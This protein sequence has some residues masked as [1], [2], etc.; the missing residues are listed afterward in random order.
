MNEDFKKKR[1]SYKKK[2]FDQFD[3]NLYVVIENTY[4][5]LNKHTIIIHIYMYINRKKKEEQKKA[6]RSDNA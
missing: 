1:L 4:S 6:Q 2:I 3:R 5:V